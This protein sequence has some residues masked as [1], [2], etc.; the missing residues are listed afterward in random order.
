MH[1][2]PLAELSHVTVT[3]RRQTILS[4]VSLSVNT[5][6]FYGLIGPNG[7][8]KSTLLGL[9][10]GLTHAASGCVMFEGTRLTTV[11]QRRLRHDI[12]H[13]FQSIPVDAQM[14]VTVFETVLSGTFGRLG[15]FRSPGRAEHDEALEALNAVGM[16][17]L[18]DRPLGSLSGGQLQR[19]AIARAI[20]QKPKLM[21][22]DE[23][24]S[25]LDWE[26]QRGILHLIAD[27][28]KAYG[29]AVV[30]ATHDLNAV[31]QL[32]TRAILLQ[33]GRILAVG[34]SETV[35]TSERLSA[36]YRVPIDVSHVNGR[37]V[38]LF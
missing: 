26:A 11:S 23:P 10:N 21:L 14:P 25:A 27:L 31:L 2:A 30:M 17:D 34:D 4:D 24:T 13:V 29:F 32:C 28:Q 15:L 9:F 6:D 18:A 16:A 8:G 12:G 1:Q 22:L 19:T 37:P 7:A 38:V 3:V 20:A 35:M 36:L 5:G 33:A